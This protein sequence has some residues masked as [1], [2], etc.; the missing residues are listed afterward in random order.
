[1]QSTK[2][3]AANTVLVVTKTGAAYTPNATTAQNNAQSWAFIKAQIAKGNNTYGG[4]QQAI[5]KAHNH[6]PMVGYTV[7]RGWLAA[8]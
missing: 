2:A 6:A 5:A 3:L 8:K 7:C 1:M 4:L